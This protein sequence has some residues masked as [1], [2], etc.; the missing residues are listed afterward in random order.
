MTATVPARAPGQAGTPVGLRPARA[1]LRDGTPVVLGPLTPADGPELLALHEGLAER[2]RWL[3]FATLHPAD[4]PGYVRRSLDP[5][6]GNLTLGARVRG[7][8]A[9][10]VQLF[11]LGDGAAE[12][13]VVV[14]GHERLAGVATALL[15][16]VAAEATRLGIGRLVAQV[17]AENGP[18]LRVL[19]DLGLAVR[20]RAQGT[21]VLVEVTL[22][23]G[24]RY[25]EAAEERHRQAAAAGLQ[26]VLRPRAITVVGAGRGAGSIGRA[27]LRELRA[28]GFPGPV[29]VVNP[30]CGELEGFPC[31]SSVAELPGPVDLAVVCVP[32]GAVP[33]VAAACG[34]HGVR[35]LLV[36]SGGLSAVPGLA[37]EV[38]DTADRYG[39]RIVGPNSVGVV[40]PGDPSR[41]AACFGG[42]VPPAGDVGLVAQSGGVVIAGGQVLG[43]LGLGVSAAVSIGDAWDVGARDVLAWCDED[44]GTAAV[45][46]YAESEPDLRGLVRTAAHLARR[47]PVLGLRTATSPAGARAAAS[48]TA[49]SATPAR[50]REAAWAAAGVQVVPDLTTLAAATAH[51][52]GRPPLRPGTVAVLTNLGGAGVLTADACVAAGLPVDPLPPALQQRLREALP[53]LAVPANPVDTGA[54]VSPGQFGAALGCLLDDPAVAAVVTVT[55]PTGVGDPGPGVAAAVAAAGDDAVAVVDVRP[56]RPTSLER[57]DPAGTG[58]GPALVS[59]NEPAVAAAVLAAAAGRAAWLAAPPVGSVPEGADVRAA[60][61][62]AAAVLDRSP[63]GDWLDPDAV[64]ALLAA[65]GVPLVPTRAAGTPGAAAAAAR[66]LACPVAVKGRVRGVVHKADAG[67]VRLPVDDPDEVRRVVGGWAAAAGADWLGAVVQPFVPPGDELLVGAVRDAAAGPVVVVGPGG[68]AADALG[69]RV[70]RLAPLDARGAEQAV[71]ATGLFATAHGRT[72]DRAAVADRLHRVAWL[73]DAVPEL[74]ELDVNPLVVGPR[75]AQAL[76]VRVRVAPDGP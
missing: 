17:L 53:P 16:Q 3:R 48:H 18:M 9:G 40:A 66:E 11:P 27:V 8:L 5:A 45:V 13:A 51:L 59:V 50:V 65:A 36:L 38:L 55:A 60:R 28:A 61:A 29:T 43:R 6:G 64:A 2:D 26:A 32:A 37:G 7:R 73:A 62:V 35:A 52:R 56:G 1:L 49:R 22:D 25:L 39:M 46:L 4:L 70:H 72:L 76:D 47:V 69:G 21:D 68:R 75:G 15:E 71:D 33:A 57:L 10:A 23:A 42:S 34:V 67:L 58:G 30:A 41:L 54:A 24:A 14:D 63:A 19:A 74:A 31:V 20:R 44:P 12:I